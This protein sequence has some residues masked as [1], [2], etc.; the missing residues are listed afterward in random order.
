[1]ENEQIFLKVTIHL[2]IFDAIFNDTLGFRNCIEKLFLI[3]DLQYAGYTFTI[4]SLDASNKRDILRNL[5]QNSS[6][7]SNIKIMAAICMAY[8]IY[9]LKYWE[10]IMNAANQMNLVSN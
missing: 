1:M 6:Y 7:A 4:E 8:S 5:A 9:N 10:V 2:C 3:S